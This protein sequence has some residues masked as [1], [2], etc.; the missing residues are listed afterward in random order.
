LATAAGY[1]YKKDPGVMTAT[2][3]QQEAENKRKANGSR[4]RAPGDKLRVI[5]RFTNT[6]QYASL[7]RPT[8]QRIERV[9]H[10]SRLA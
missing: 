9:E 5:R 6:A 4:E 10:V 1:S 8:L 2:V 7:L 3:S